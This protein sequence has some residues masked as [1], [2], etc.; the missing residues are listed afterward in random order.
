ME[1]DEVQFGILWYPEWTIGENWF[2]EAAVCW[3]VLHYRI[4][5]V[6]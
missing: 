2:A 3:A 6:T 5:E 4:M 1:K